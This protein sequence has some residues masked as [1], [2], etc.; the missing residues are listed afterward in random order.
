MTTLL[1]RH[2]APRVREALADTRIVVI[3]GARQVGKTTLARGIVEAGGGS[4]VTLDDP[5]IRAAAQADPVGFLDHGDDL[6]VVD[7]VQRVPE[8]VLALK[9]HVDR[10]PRPGRFLVTGSANLLRMPTVED[11]LAGRA[12][13]IELHGFSQGELAGQREGFIDRLLSGDRFAA[14]VSDLHRHDYLERAIAGGYPD[15]LARAAGP[16]RDQWLDDYLSR[17]ATRDAPDL[18]DARRLDRLPQ[19]LRLIAARNAEE[20]NRSRL[21]TESEIPVR[22]LAP[23]LD[24]LETL[25]LVQLIPSWSTNLS[26]RVVSRPKAALLDCGLV[27]RLLRVSA[28]GLRRQELGVAA[29]HLLEGFVA[30]ELRRQ[31]VWSHERP[32]ISHYRDHNGAE[33]DLILETP[34]GRIAA[35]EVKAGAVVGAKDARWIA[36]LRDRLGD[37]FVGGVVLCSGSRSGSLGDRISAVPMDAL[38]RS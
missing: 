29:G 26:A 20:L 30:G 32:V 34:D 12:E 35:I 8:L 7:E 19:I 24:L 22:S 25:Y 21:A 10:D 37:R 18:S 38:W 23:L 17:I 5:A 27:G 11:S 9:L 4:L 14:H 6:L 36:Q 16:R 13:T 33:V 1:E 2:V 31:L 28:D 3:E 15:A